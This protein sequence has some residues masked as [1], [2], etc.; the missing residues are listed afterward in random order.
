MGAKGASMGRF[1][2]KTVVIVEDEALVAMDLESRLGW[3]GF[4]VL[5]VEADGQAAVDLILKTSPDLVLLDIHLASA[6][7][8][9]DVAMAIAG[10]NIGVVFLTAFSDDETI[11]RA[12]ATTPYGYIIKPFDERTLVA[13]LSVALERHDAD[14][15]LRVIKQVI[16]RAEVGI[17]LC[18]VMHEEL[19]IPV[20]TNPSFARWATAAAV[21][22]IVLDACRHL[23]MSGERS[24]TI[25]SSI[26]G[27]TLSLHAERVEDDRV[28]IFATDITRLR[29]TE[30]LLEDSQRQELVSRVAQGIA[31]DFNNELT[32]IILLTELVMQRATSRETEDELLLIQQSATRASS[33]TRQLLELTKAGEGE[34]IELGAA[35]ALLAPLLSRAASPARLEVQ[36]TARG[37]RCAIS[38]TALAQML[39]N[40]IINGRDATT[41]KTGQLNLSIFV[42][43]GRARLHFEDNGGGMSREIAARAFDPGFTTKGLGGNGLG[44][45]MVRSIAERF[46]GAVELTSELGRGTRIV[47]DLPVRAERASQ[48]PTLVG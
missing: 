9:I 36:G 47:V 21:R 5:G 14:E 40:L 37:W 15:Q 20:L 2:G 19:I 22:G 42:Q 41:G 25:I 29:Q 34:D 45:M 31:H 33:L 30:A 10:A 6:M 44:L 32:V 28:A 11:A 23:L 4:R 38:S 8:G 39:M 16:E 7:S 43:D 17:F 27:K 26:D 48:V 12:S 46:G 1:T 3:L 35:V 24:R 18:E 13:T